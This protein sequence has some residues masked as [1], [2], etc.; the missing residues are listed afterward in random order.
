MQQQVEVSLRVEDV[1]DIWNTKRRCNMIGMDFF[2]ETADICAYGPT[3][4]ISINKAEM[5]VIFSRNLDYRSME[6]ADLAQ[7]WIIAESAKTEQK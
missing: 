1:A 3:S 2:A 4:Q 6:I 5:M 7:I